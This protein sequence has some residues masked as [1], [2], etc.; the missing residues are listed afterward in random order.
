MVFVVGNEKYEN[1][2]FHILSEDSQTQ[3][4]EFFLTPYFTT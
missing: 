3:Y 1:A 2:L 4:K